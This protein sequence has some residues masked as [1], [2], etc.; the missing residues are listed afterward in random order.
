MDKAK[1]SSLDG[2]KII[3]NWGKLSVSLRERYP[4]LTEADLKL[5]PGKEDELVKRVSKRLNKNHDEVINII[6][7]DFEKKSK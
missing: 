5:E 3:G 1:S 2:S 6:N 4:S 7:K